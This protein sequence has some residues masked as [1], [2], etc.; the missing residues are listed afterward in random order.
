M[1]SLRLILPVLL[2]PVL[3]I[4]TN[5]PLSPAAAP[6]NLDPISCT[7]SNL[8]DG[9]IVNLNGHNFQASNSGARMATISR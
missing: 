6:W 1:K 5:K 9:A 2:S 7:F 3:L 8:P 4:L